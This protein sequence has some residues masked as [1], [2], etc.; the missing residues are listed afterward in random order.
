VDPWEYS[1]GTRNR[2]SVAGD[3]NLRRKISDIR[4]AA[5]FSSS[6]SLFRP[7]WGFHRQ[8]QPN[9]WPGIQVSAGTIDLQAA[10]QMPFMSRKIVSEIRLLSAAGTKELLDISNLDR[11]F[12]AA[13]R[14]LNAFLKIA[15]FCGF[16]RVGGGI[17]VLSLTIRRSPGTFLLVREVSNLQLTF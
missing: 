9:L 10:K 15:L 6:V 14:R 3:Q 16:L 5:G 7:L 11:I 13:G 2:R 12:S 17:S 4:R 8:H 1:E